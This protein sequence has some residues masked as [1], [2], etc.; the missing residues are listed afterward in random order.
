MNTQ[1][2]AP[3]SCKQELDTMNNLIQLGNK[4][5][6]LKADAICKRFP[7]L[8]SRYA[9]ADQNAEDSMVDCE[10]LSR[11]EAFVDRSQEQ[12]DYFAMSLEGFGVQR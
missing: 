3:L 6:N 5:Y 8:E 11:A 4:E 1:D 12:L 10:G 9:C 2:A 7:H